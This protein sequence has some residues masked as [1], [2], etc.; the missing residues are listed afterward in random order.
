MSKDLPAVGARLQQLRKSKGIS[1]EELAKASGVSK[2]MASQ[3]ER[4][5]ANPTVAVLWRLTNALNVG[6]AEFLA[7]EKAEGGKPDIAV[8]PSYATPIIRSPDGK[9]IL[10]ILG[11]PELVGRMEWYELRIAAGGVLASEPH[12]GGSKEHLSIL[13]GEV[14]VEVSGAKKRV[15]AGETVRYAVDQKHAIINDSAE[16]ATLLMVIEYA[17]E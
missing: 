2:S 14:V 15:M 16:L 3:I 12:S 5:E 10:R 4:N 1:L 9:C 17:A 13:S 11:P 6:L 8:T 7:P